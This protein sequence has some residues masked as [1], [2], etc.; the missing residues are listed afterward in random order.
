MPIQHSDELTL[1]C[2]VGTSWHMNPLREEF[3]DEK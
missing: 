2:T 1:V 3:A